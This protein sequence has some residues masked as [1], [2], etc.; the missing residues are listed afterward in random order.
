MVAGHLRPA[1]WAAGAACGRRGRVLQLAAQ[2]RPAPC[3]GRGAGLSGAQATACTAGPARPAGHGSLARICRRGRRDRA[4]GGGLFDRPGP[5]GDRDLF[6]TP[7]F[8]LRR[9]RE[10]ITNASRM[11]PKSGADAGGPGGDR[12]LDAGARVPAAPRRCPHAA[13]GGAR[14][15]PGR[16]PLRPLRRPH[17]A[18]SGGTPV[19]RRAAP[20]L[21]LDVLAGSRHRG[22]RLSHL[23][24]RAG[25]GWRARCFGPALSRGAET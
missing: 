24:R 2:A 14:R 16:Q 8:C 6:G 23:G 12:R 13:L 3:R 18:G 20:T 21:D 15:R 22:R 9:A 5:P 11:D 7:G 1:A 10:P 17:H 25:A 19:S 4:L